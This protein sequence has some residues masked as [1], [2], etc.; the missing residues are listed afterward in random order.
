MTDDILRRINTGGMISGS[1]IGR[2]EPETVGKAGDKADRFAKDCI[3]SPEDI[4]RCLS[5]PKPICTNCVAR[6]GHKPK[7]QKTGGNAWK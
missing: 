7:G 1:F 4:A 5:C 6:G 2:G 3:D